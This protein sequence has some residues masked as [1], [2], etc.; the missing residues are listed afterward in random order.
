MKIMD[1]TLRDGANV[2]GNGFPEDLTDMILRGLTENG[3]SVIEFG[4]AKGLGAEQLGFKGPVS[5]EQYFRLAKPYLGKAE[6]GMFLNAKRYKEE[7]VC[8]AAQKGLCFL[9]V[10]A[11]AGEA[12]KYPHVIKAVKD[13]GLTCRYSLMKAYLLTPAQLAQEGKTLQAYGVDEL[14][15]MDSAGC[16]LP[17]EVRES[18]EALK[19]AVCIPIGFHC[20]NNLGLSAAN[21]QAAM[22]AGVDLL[23]CGLLGMAR[24]AGNLPTEI[25]CALAGKRGE[26]KEVDFYGL[27][28]F[29]ESELI[30]EMAR[31]GYQPPITPL[32]LIL[33]YSGCHSAFLKTFQAAAKDYRVD[34]KRLIVKV[35][36]IDRKSPSEALI[37]E[38]ARELGGTV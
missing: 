10:G 8:H 20:H 5:D 1:C 35:S 24:S 25:A 32:E 6:I 12:K 37:R 13:N 28:N 15:I 11:D 33:G 18:V 17:N 9:R 2:L 14:T 29:L 7:N 36:E 34:V 4:N 31:H 19:E 27:L 30:P 22:E 3:V 26:A 38:T 23:D 21:A 16:M